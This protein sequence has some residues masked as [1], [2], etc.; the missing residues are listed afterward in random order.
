MW[1]KGNVMYKKS[2]EQNLGWRLI[3]GLLSVALT[4]VLLLDPNLPKKLE[5]FPLVTLTFGIAYILSKKINRNIKTNLGLLGLNVMLIIRYLIT[6]SLMW[7]GGYEV[8]RGI[9]PSEGN[10]NLAVFLMILE[11]IVIFTVIEIFGNKFYKDDIV[12][13]LKVKINKNFVGFTF[14]LVCLLIII[15]FPSILNNYSF[16]F[17]SSIEKNDSS[18]LPFGSFL[19]LI[20]QFGLMFLTITLINLIYKINKSKPSAMNVYLSIIIVFLSSS[21][22]LGDSRLGVVIPMVTGM[23]ILIRI[24]PEYIRKIYLLF[25]IFITIVIIVTTLVTQYGISDMSQVS[26]GMKEFYKSSASLF[27]VYFSGIHN[28][29]V[30]IKAAE[31]FSLEISTYTVFSD[32]FAS[33][34][35]IS[36]FFSSNFGAVSMFNFAFYNNSI[37]TDQILPMLGQGYIYFGVVFAPVFSG[38]FVFAMMFFDKKSKESNSVFEIYIYAYAAVRFGL[39]FMSNATILTSFF[40]NYFLLLLILIALNKKIVLK[41]S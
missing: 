37:S 25:G 13:N 23:Y 5:Y 31:L 4:I 33:V 26:G 12:K 9:M 3:V 18:N 22:I 8:T 15:V 38:V 30:S 6:P 7:I 29:A 17:S 19:P 39:F 10:F 1:R 35:L 24:Y 27:Q 41:N 40:T 20:V 34:I 21:F 36:D 14:L 28:I 2:K 16:I 11:I 32:L